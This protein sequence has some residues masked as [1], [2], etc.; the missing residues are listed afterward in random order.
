[1]E[2]EK[3]VVTRR[4]FLAG[5]GT[6]AAG[7]LAAGGVMGLVN[8]LPAAAAAPALPWP[9]LTLYDSATPSDPYAKVRKAAYDNYKTG[10]ACCYGIASALVNS[11]VS[12]LQ[13]RAMD[14]SMWQN[15]PLDMFVWGRGG[16]CES[17]TLCGALSGALPIFNLVAYLPA[18]NINF[19]FGNISQLGKEL[20]TWYSENALPTTALDAYSSFKNQ[21]QSIAKSPLCHDSVSRWLVQTNLGITDPTKKATVYSPA[22]V[23]RCA[24]LTGDVAV[25]AAYLLDQWIAT[26][27]P[28]TYLASPSPAEYAGCLGC[29]SGT[30]SQRDDSLGYMNCLPCHPA[31]A[32]VPPLNP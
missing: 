22:R 31:S 30:T 23:E 18:E 32:H 21:A 24:K 16:G 12:A 6:A 28:R 5:A 1:M 8:P 15:L 19:N 26:A 17:G 29:H 7:A 9:Y 10:K 25:M 20:L 2:Q 4:D 13:A 11:T 14:A 3:K 27:P